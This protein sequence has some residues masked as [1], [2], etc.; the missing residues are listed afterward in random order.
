MAAITDPTFKP[1]QRY[2]R[3]RLQQGVPIAD[4]DW[5]E[6]DDIRAFE[7][8]AFLKWYVG[9][10]VPDGNDGFLVEAD[11]SDGDFWVRRGRPAAPAGSEQEV[12]ALDHVGRC[13]VDGLDVIIAADTRFTDQPLHASRPDAEDHARRLRVPVVAPLEPPTEDGPVVVYLD[14]WE[15]LVTPDEVPELVLGG[16]GIETC[17][18]VCREW[19]VRVRP[20][21]TAPVPGESDRPEGHTHLTGH[22]YLPLARVQRRSERAAVTPADVRDV[23]PRRLLLPPAHLLA[24]TLGVDP[25]RYRAGEDRPAVSLREAVN[26]LLAGELPSS[27]D[28]EV[29]PAPGLD[30]GGR[31]MVVD[32]R[33][34]LVVVW[35]SPRSGAVNQV[36]ASRLDLSAGK[37]EFSAAQP[38]TTGGPHLAPTV[39]ALPGDDLLVAYQ[40]GLPGSPGTDVVMKRAPFGE[41]RTAAEQPVAAT[42]GQPDVRPFAVVVGELAVVFTYERGTQ[43]WRYTRY[44]HTD[45]TRLDDD[46]LHLADADNPT[47]DLHAAAAPGGVVWCGFVSGAQVRAVRLRPST[48]TV[49]IPATF[50]SPGSSGVFVVAES[51]SSA[52][53]YWTGG[54]DGA[55]IRHAACRNGAWGPSALLPGSDSGDRDPSAVVDAGG[56]TW[57]LSTRTA[58]GDSHIVVRTRHPVTGDWSDR[59]RVVAT[60]GTDQTP[61][62]LLVPGQGIWLL[63]TSSRGGETN[64]FAKRLVTAL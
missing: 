44:R 15:H 6:Q 16:L 12:T 60:T 38:L 10:G 49:D 29:S 37:P 31:G 47:S 13:L 1:L 41:L 14:V 58:D 8:R 55:G 7:L 50:P 56:R 36:V 25:A 59:R 2:V 39:V 20:G 63:W 43:S 64:L 30:L 28:I 18:R 57:L 45:G 33:G 27:R 54:G 3:V 42:A 19:V 53:V 32:G 9:D 35:Q 24:D 34:G 46:S 5:N 21:T 48:E 51:E 61:Y 17:A 62:G 22:W 26:A 23:R 52:E 11:G 40:A 4:A